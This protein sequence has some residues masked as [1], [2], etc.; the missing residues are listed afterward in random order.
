MIQE[1]ER[2]VAVFVDAGAD[3]PSNEILKSKYRIEQLLKF[4]Y[5]YVSEKMNM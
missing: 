3:L 5:V 4:H 1:K 2:K